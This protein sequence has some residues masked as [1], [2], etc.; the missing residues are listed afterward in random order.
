MQKQVLCIHQWIRPKGP[1]VEVEGTGN[2][3]KCI[4]DEKNCEC[5]RYSLIVF[6][7]EEEEN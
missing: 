1:H 4:P 3:N 6:Y 5:K 2:C 7:I